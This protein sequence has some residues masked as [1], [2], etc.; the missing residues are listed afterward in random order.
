MEN[1][2]RSKELIAATD[3]I[4]TEQPQADADAHEPLIEPPI[5]EHRIQDD[6]SS[7]SPKPIHYQP[8]EQRRSF[9]VEWKRELLTYCLGTVGMILMLVLLLTFR[10]KPSSAWKSKI[11]ITAVIAGLSQLAQSALIVSVSSTLGQLKWNWFSYQRRPIRDLDR[12]DQATRGPEG[13][14]MLLVDSFRRLPNK[15]T[16]TGAT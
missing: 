9:W 16:K 13:S 11:Q 3:T 12:Y 15:N 6:H 1:P 5:E 8:P 4:G 10:G 7:I 14:L 2:C